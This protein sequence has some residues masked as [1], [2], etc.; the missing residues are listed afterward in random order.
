[1]ARGFERLCF[2][3]DVRYPV[4][5]VQIR[6]AL[7]KNPRWGLS[8]L[9][10]EVAASAR[11]SVTTTPFLAG[12]GSIGSIIPNARLAAAARSNAITALWS[13]TAMP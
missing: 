5:G 1:M 11:I 12:K 9:S 6:N 10:A 13:D 7:R 3:K 8:K 2:S 4:A